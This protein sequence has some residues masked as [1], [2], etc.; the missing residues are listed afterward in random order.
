MQTLKRNDTNELI[1]EAETDSQVQRVDLWSPAGGAG[2]GWLGNRGLAC[3]HRCSC[4]L[5]PSCPTLR[6]HGLQPARLLCPWDSPGK[7]TGGSWLP[8]PPPGDLPNLGI[9]PR[10]PTLQAD[11]LPSEPPEKPGEGFGIWMNSICQS[12]P[13]YLPVCYKPGRADWL[14]QGLFFWQ[15][16]HPLTIWLIVFT[17][18]FP[19]KDS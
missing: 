19:L 13:G 14:L 2:V 11:S 5:A 9:K 10:F 4:Q 8:C 1:Y 6:P 16:S 7:N 3:T 18:P 15:T 17:N 12:S